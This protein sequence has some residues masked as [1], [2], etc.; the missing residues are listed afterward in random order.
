MNSRFIGSIFLII[1][2]TIGAGMLSLPLIVAACGFTT[3]IILLVLSWSVMYITALRLLDVCVQHPIGVNFTTMIWSRAPKIYLV[4]FSIIYLLLLYSL[5]SAYTTQGSSLISML[6]GVEHQSSKSQV[7]ISAIVFILIFGAL[8]FSY[9]ASDYT[10]RVFVILK[11][12]FF[13]IAMVIMLFYINMNYLG[14]EPAG[15]SA[16]IFAWPTLLPAFGFH[17]IIPVIYEYQKGD[18]KSI[19][20]SIF[21]GSV[22]VLTVYVIWV[23]I[24]LGLVPQHGSFSYHELFVSGNNTPSGLVNAIR[25][26]SG[27]DTLEIALNLFIHIAVITS[28][29]GVG[30]SLMHYIR[31]LFTKNNK[32]IS[33]WVLA[34]I[35][36]V[37]PL[38][39]TVFYPQGFILALEYAAIFAVI[40]FVYTPAFLTVRRDLKVYFSHT[41]VV[42][43]GSAVILF[44]IFNLCFNINP[45]LS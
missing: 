27:S 2:T 17:N 26:I 30:I 43:M 5:L 6:G 24:S 28:F 34:L 18:V 3:A 44:E 42:S 35:C 20:R 19:R 13:I 23:F 15:V 9:R 45:F 36:F 39:F 41:Y 1:G 37:P 33:S 31:D 38:I 12:M 10:N 11:F 4:F 29:I 16:I 25:T 14:D 40:I 32:Q 21:I 8:V 22:S 7:G